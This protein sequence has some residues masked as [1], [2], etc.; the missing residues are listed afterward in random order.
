MQLLL[1]LLLCSG[2]QAFVLAVIKPPAAVLRFAAPGESIMPVATA[3]NPARGVNAYPEDIR[4]LRLERRVKTLER[5][6][7]AV[8]GLLAH[9]DDLALLE[10][11]TC[12]IGPVFLDGSFTSYRSPLLLR[13]DIQRIMAENG[14]SLTP[15]MH[16]WK[17][18]SGVDADVFS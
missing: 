9:C 8:G 17:P 14:F 2:T 16:T 18:V 12:T 4:M 15:P 13:T 11:E 5:T 10:R 1:L 3:P 7:P 6:L